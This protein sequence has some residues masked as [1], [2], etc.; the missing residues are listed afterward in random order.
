MLSGLKV[1]NEI[2]VKIIDDGKFSEELA[3]VKKLGGRYQWSDKSWIFDISKED[4]LK[5]CGVTFYDTKMDVKYPVAYVN[6]DRAPF[7]RQY[8]IA[9]LQY[10]LSHNGRILLADDVG[11]GKTLSSIGFFAYTKL[12]YPLLIVTTASTKSQWEYEYNRFN[13]WG[14][15]TH[16]CEGLQS[17]GKI[18]ADV[19]IINYDILSYHVTNEGSKWNPKYVP[20]EALKAL[21]GMEFQG[22]IL[23]ECQRLKSNTS[24][25]TQ[26][27]LHL[28]KD[29]PYILALSATPIEN[30]PKEFYNV[31]HILRPDI[32]HNY[33]SFIYRY[34][35]AHKAYRY[36]RYGKTKKK[37][38]YIDDTG[39]SNQEELFEVLRH[40]V[41][42]RRKKHEAIEGLPKAIPVT[43]PLVMADQDLKT[44]HDIL[45][46]NEKIFTKSGKEIAKDNKLVKKNYLKEF[47]ANMKMEYVMQFLTDFLQDNDEKIVVF[48]EHHA[49]IDELYAKFKKHSTIYDGRCSAKEKDASK[50]KFIEDP[51]CRIIF[52]Q[53]KALGEGVDKMQNVCNKMMIVELPYNPM[54]I[55]QAIGRLERIGSNSDTVTVYFP[56][57]RN[58]VEEDIMDMITDKTTNLLAIL[59]GKDTEGHN[60]G[61][62]ITDYLH[63]KGLDTN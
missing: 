63:S 18:D 10:M 51:N 24:L 4:E 44:Y 60:I 6:K 23:D 61:K 14:R 20:S 47:S 48:T 57:L 58:T 50:S 2:Q 26:A 35:N 27:I 9:P 22:L 29:I 30:K 7:L 25:W 52:G 21:K 45:E 33:N 15:T 59:D 11:L 36:I 16:V 40:H 34:C 12:N 43:I 62:K 8:Q 19:V 31:L 1:N 41:M 49:I 54:L 39:A 53:I 5:S 3:T 37:Q 42:F 55:Y 13:T 32:W 46:G 17:V 38:E 28:A 56:I